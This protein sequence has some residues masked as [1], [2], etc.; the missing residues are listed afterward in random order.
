MI[1]RSTSL[2]KIL[3]VPEVFGNAA[4]TILNVVDFPAPLGPNKP[5]IYFSLTSKELLRIAIYPLGYFLYKFF[6]TIGFFSFI[7][8]LLNYTYEPCY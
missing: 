8:Y 4:V 6:I 2:S 7:L 3:T 1:P 5:N